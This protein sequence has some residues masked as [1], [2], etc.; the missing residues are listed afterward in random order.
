[1]PT[2]CRNPTV[3]TSPDRLRYTRM[4]SGAWVRLC[5]PVPQDRAVAGEVTCGA[6]GA[7]SATVARA[8]SS[9]SRRPI[10]CWVWNAALA[11]SWTCGNV[12]PPSRR[13][14]AL[15]R[16]ERWSWCRR[17]QQAARCWGHAQQ[18]HPADVAA[19]T[20][21]RLRERWNTGI[22]S[23]TT[24]V[25]LRTYRPGRRPRQ[26][27]TG[28]TLP[29]GRRSS[30]SSLD[31]SGLAVPSLSAEATPDPTSD[32]RTF[33]HAPDRSS[34]SPRLP[35]RRRPTTRSWTASRGPSGSSPDVG[36]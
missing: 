23:G 6:S 19:R 13:N 3:S 29:L 25:G 21:T 14:I 4:V 5:Q 18:E 24:R 32:D 8:P 30:V 17:Q 28:R 20:R 35:P 2:Y 11:L 10:R 34:R 15:T 7:A 36:A 22:T 12:P 27:T 1:M 26:S 16:H 9:S 31:S 33:R